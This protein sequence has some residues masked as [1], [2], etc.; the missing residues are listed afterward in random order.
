VERDGNG[1]SKE[2]EAEVQIINIVEDEGP[3]K[4]SDSPEA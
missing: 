2:V 3:K 4:P 1:S